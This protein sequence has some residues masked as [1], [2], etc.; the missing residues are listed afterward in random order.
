MLPY[1]HFSI[2]MN[3]DR[4]LAF[5]T[6]VNIDGN[7]FQRPDD[8]S[9]NWSFDDRIDREA[10]LAGDFYGPDEW[11]DEDDLVRLTAVIIETVRSGPLGIARGG[12]RLSI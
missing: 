2:V 4:R 12:K 9:G 10:Q 3:R 1:R 5:F 7:Q 11:V 8:E 6:A